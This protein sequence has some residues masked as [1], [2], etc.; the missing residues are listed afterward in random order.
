[1]QL[2][3]FILLHAPYALFSVSFAVTSL[4]EALKLLFQA[5]RIACRNMLDGPILLYIIWCLTA[6]KMLVIYTTIRLLDPSIILLI[7]I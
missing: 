4:E 2:V 5:H 1:M 7:Y 3:L 6:W